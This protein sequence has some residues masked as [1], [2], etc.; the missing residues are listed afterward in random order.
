MRLNIP[1][2]WR[3]I[4]LGDLDSGTRRTIDPREYPN[5]VFEYYSIPAYQEK[6][7]PIATKGTEI[8]S[9]KILL[10]PRS[11]LFGKLN[12]RVEKVWRVRTSSGLRQIGSTEWLPIVPSGEIDPDF[13]YF[14][15]WSEQVMHVA[16][17]QVSGSTPSRQRVDPAAFYRIRIPIPPKD[18]QRR[19]AAVLSAVKRAIDRQER[20]ITLTAEF[21]KALMHKLFSE[22]ARGEALRQT[23][24]GPVPE[25]WA[26][27]SL[28]QFTE[29]FQ[30]GTSVKCGY[31]VKGSP[32]LRIPNVVGGH[33]DVTDLKFGIPKKN[34]VETVRLRP[35]DV[36]FVRTNGVRENAGR[37]SMY[38]GE[39][40]DSCYFASYLIRIR[41]GDGL[42]PA[43]LEEYTRTENGIRLL[44]GRAARTADGKFNINT[45]TL[46]TLLVPKPDIDE[47]KLI[48]DA[49]ASIDRK[50]RNHAASKATLEA[51]FRTL[52]HQLMTAKIRVHNLELSAL[53]EAA[54]LVGVA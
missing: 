36:L 40:G 28:E 13:L 53:E 20:L 3:L 14:L 48:V 9:I 8:A 10:E 33:L 15:C 50:A 46:E 39:L 54:E 19:I 29:S 23:E 18:E 41:L 25:S 6:Q 45:G 32:V 26:V 7:A 42:M 27:A 31:D 30:Y 4:A 24:I 49:L 5:E 37:C 47:Q 43:F 35:G 1:P 2:T 11:V 12:P 51:L 52:L 44:A 34:E 21:K 22:G 16:K 17:G 38:R